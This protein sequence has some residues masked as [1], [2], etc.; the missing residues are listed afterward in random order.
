MEILIRKIK[1]DLV[2][3]K[4]LLLIV[5]FFIYFKKETLLEVGNNWIFI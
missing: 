4:I 5:L 3:V 2:N 1:R